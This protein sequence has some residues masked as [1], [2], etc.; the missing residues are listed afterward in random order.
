MILGVAPAGCTRVGV[1]A[2]SLAAQAVAV[3][4]P[5]GAPV[6]WG[7]ALTSVRA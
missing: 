6:W 4:S 1:T 7:R 5:R 3:G 2:A